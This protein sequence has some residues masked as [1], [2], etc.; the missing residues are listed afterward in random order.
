MSVSTV[1]VGRTA[2]LAA[3]RAASTAAMAGRGGLVLLTGEPGIGKT[4]LLSQVAREAAADGSRVLWGR[5]WDGA[6]APAYWPWTQVLRVTGAELGAAARLAAADPDASDPTDRFTLFDTVARL[7][8]DLA[9][10]QPLVVI[11]DDLQWADP[12]SLALLGFCGH[13][14]SDDAVLLL[15]AYRDLEAPTAITGLT[16]TGTIIPLTGLRPDE[17][18]AMVAQLVGTAPEPGVAER[19]WRRTGGNPFFIGELTRLR[20]SRGAVEG[21]DQLAG[22]IPAGIRETVERR[23]ARLSQPCVEML[24]V[25]AVAGPVVHP[26]ILAR[27]LPGT[28]AEHARLIA[29]AIEAQVMVSGPD[30]LDRPAF[31][32]DLFRETLYSGVTVTAQARLHRAIAQ[33]LETLGHATPV[34]PAEIAAHFLA[35]ASAGDAQAVEAAVRYSRTAAEDASARLADDDAAAHYRRALAAFDLAPEPP[36]TI[37]RLDLMLDLAAAQ[38]R[39]GETA[40]ARAGYRAVAAQARTVDDPDRFAAAALGLHDLGA[41]RGRAHDE[42][43]ALLSEA[44]GRL[45]GRLTGQRARVLAA[46]AGDL[47]HSWEQ[48]RINRAPAVAEE[49]VALA[50]ELDDPAV[51]AAALLAQHDARWVP[52]SAAA[53]LLII[54]ELLDLA[55]ATA[56]REAEAT[57]RLL[58]ATALVELGDPRGRSDLATYC[59]LAADLGHSRGRWNALARGATAA[60]IAGQISDA[61][62]LSQHAS[63][64]GV[65][66]G[67]PDARNVAACQT[68]DI[69][70]FTGRRS[71]RLPGSGFAPQVA[72]WP[73]WHAIGHADAGDPAAAAAALAGV[74]TDR[75]WDP[76]LPIGPDPWGIAVMAEAVAAAGTPEH[77]H[78]LYRLLSPLAGT[79]VVAGGLATYAG[80]VDFYLGLLATALD[81]EDA[82]AHHG[83]ALTAAERLGAACWIELCA[84]KHSSTTTSPRGQGMFRRESDVWTLTWAGTTIRLPDAKGLHDI[85]ALLASPGEPV[86]AVMLVTGRPPSTGADAV[87]DPRAIAAYRARLRELDADVAD[88][89]ADHDPRRAEL[90]RDERDALIHELSQ[91]VGPG[92]RPRRLGSDGERARK[93]VTGRIRDSIDRI[94]R[95]HPA[96]ADHLHMSI[97]T[98]T[99]CRYHTAEHVHWQL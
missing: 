25:A 24:T 53:R 54:G 73:P 79:H 3:L 48:P 76:A 51:L 39:M 64:Y 96:L 98:G 27:M 2:E 18:G 21:V 9:G 43:L 16:A 90:A 83:A 12:G 61:A 37:A 15:G 91:A 80:P 99:T 84:E 14:L 19:T 44:T 88:A 63:H 7:L 72:A 77:R 89:E 45:T 95:H 32:H 13:Q 92:G 97:S 69:D 62:Q 10:Q 34:S 68:W 11:L 67:E 50:R 49:A 40:D 71:E 93:A 20:L 38:H 78:R 33:A 22:P 66:I 26:G 42:P 4:A 1:L 46:M 74:D 6:G 65:Q 85:A 41:P 5:C 52:G 28:P 70:R 59:D 47:F 17:V 57:A 82:A 94:A 87:L 75:G 30:A 36:P 35:A 60:L 56:D 8:T 29:E 86:H 23:L 55:T 31:A 58:R 81:Q